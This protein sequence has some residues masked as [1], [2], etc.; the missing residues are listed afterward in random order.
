M[1]L[2]RVLLNTILACSWCKASIT[3]PETRKG[4]VCDACGE[5]Y[6]PLRYTWEMIPSRHRQQEM[7]SDLWRAWKQLQDNGS[8]SYQMDPEHNLSVGER[9][10]CK[11][12]SDFCCFRGLVLDVG[13]GPQMWPAYFGDPSSQ[14]IFVGIDPLVGDSDAG[15]M[16]FRA[17]GELLPFQTGVF[18]HVVFATSLDHTVE[19]LVA[20]LEAK[21]VC[22]PGGQI[23]IWFGEKRPGESRPTDPSG[24]YADLEKPDLAEDVFHMVLL[25]KDKVFSLLHQAGLDIVEHTEMVVDDYHSHFFVRVIV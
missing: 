10:D 6:A 18:D 11:A 14:A 7:S 15:Y 2:D 4:I 25:R 16:Q 22:R 8:I 19:P 23:N 12:F 17:L 1:E 24:W 20:L 9:E 13:C 3:L 5:V 21:R